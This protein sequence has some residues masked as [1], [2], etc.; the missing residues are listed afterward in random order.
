MSS[1][2]QIWCVL[3]RLGLRSLRQ[4]SY[5]LLGLCI[6]VCSGVAAALSFFSNSVHSALDADIANYLGAPMVIRA[7][8]SLVPLQ[9]QWSEF[10]TLQKPVMTS[11]FTTG[12]IAQTSYQS[13]SLKGVS[14]NYPLQGELIIKVDYA[15]NAVSAG[16]L[17][18]G[19]VWLDQR[20]LDELRL[21][22][23][24]KVQIGQ[25]SL[26]VVAVIVHEPDRLTQLQHALPRAMVNLKTL[27]STG[28]GVGNN[29]GE[30][31]ILLAGDETILAQIEANLDR[32]IDG[33]YEVLKPS[34]GRHPFSRISVRAERLL[35][36]VLVLILLMCGGAAASLA[37]HTVR[38]FAMAATV[39]RC[40]GVKRRSVSSA[41]CLQLMGLAVIV[42]LVGC[43]LA[44]AIQPLL[45]GVMEP[46][47]SLTVAP[48]S[49]KDLIA[50]TGIGL[51]TV[52]AF[53]IPKLQQLGSISVSSVLR[54][55]IE[56][57]KRFY[58]VP[59]IASAFVTFMLWYSSDNMQLTMILVGAVFALVFLS[60]GFGWL[61]SKLSAQTHRLV[62]GPVKVSIR[63][64]G[65][66]P[67]RHITPL[68]SV[69]IAM[70][71]VLMTVTLRGS[72]LEMLQVQILET[73]GNYVFT[74]LPASQRDAFNASVKT[75]GAKV[76]S[77]H[78]TVS[79]RLVAING[80]D[81][82]DA[83]NKESDTREETRSRVR[84]SWAHSLPSNNRLLSG[85]WPDKA[86]SDV[87]VEAEVMTDLGL[88][89]GDTLT[90]QIGEQS[91]TTTITSQREYKGGGSRMMFWFMFAENALATFE[92]HTMGGLMI[93][94][95]AQKALSKLG[96]QFPQVRINNL[97]RQ[98]SGIRDIM[99]VLTRLMNTTLL[100]LL[101][102]ALVVIVSTS[103]VSSDNRNK[104][105]QLMRA[106]GLRRL[107]CYIM[108]ISE[109][110]VVGA[111]A[112]LVG[113]LGVQ[114]IA[115]TLFHN[116]FSMSY[117]LDWARVITLT[118]VISCTFAG[119]GGFFAFRQLKKPV[120]LD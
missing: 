110:W 60:T 52:L 71:A 109:Q 101:S 118:A 89:I 46:H 58:A 47:M 73:D 68:A 86:S 28:V 79:A 3:R 4:K 11:S 97:E 14:E 69:S 20:A 92:Q 108:N 114:L 103:F 90:F 29:R 40:M 83:L 91:L 100:L 65:R 31:R 10:T 25:A 88:Q 22:V 16:Q 15:E 30:H 82:D 107:Q 17:N 26:E 119:I 96:S 104:Q 95:P 54:G 56:P 9:N 50:P 85:Q 53:V 5:G 2:K 116:L 78:P 6:L 75:V 98:I 12:A 57:T 24:D 81:I 62:R 113:A 41:L 36:V 21:N 61:L 48:I 120:T 115:G 8:S 67:S 23:G 51:V 72:F 34:K 63:S 18:D 27:T 7:D 87:S 106:L 70:M 37:D 99:I 45:I 66:S 19:E 117:Q 80:V 64:I 43:L 105:M 111:V 49:L 94:N 44:W 55:Q 32:H 1:I 42:S 35:N 77:S 74:G 84:L 33:D 93:E 102:G 39:L 112:C 59:I 76:K 13:V 38:H